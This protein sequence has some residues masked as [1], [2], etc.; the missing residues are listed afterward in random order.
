MILRVAIGR[1]RKWVL[2][3]GWMWLIP[4]VYENSLR[5][6][7]TEVWEGFLIV[8]FWK[9]WA[10]LMSKTDWCFKTIDLKTM[11]DY[12]III[13]NNGSSL[14][15]L[16]KT[17]N[18]LLKASSQKKV[19][20]W[21]DYILAIYMDKI[22]IGNGKQLQYSCLESSRNRGACQAAVCGVSKIWTWL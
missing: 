10:H 13:Y 6:W 17:I 21:R 9:S 20:P 19:F 2:S 14:Q 11:W 1:S 3:E 4:R 8:L 5:L 15:H 22:G 16:E 12:I 7:N 18:L